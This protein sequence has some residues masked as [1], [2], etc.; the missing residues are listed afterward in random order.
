M[1]NREMVIDEDAYFEPTTEDHYLDAAIENR[2]G[3]LD[4]ENAA[5]QTYA[6]SLNVALQQAEAKKREAEKILAEGMNEYDSARAVEGTKALS[7][8]QR[9]FEALQQARANLEQG[10]NN[11]VNENALTREFDGYILKQPPR[12]QRYLKRRYHDIA[13]N[14]QNTLNKLLA[15]D[16]EARR[17]GIPVESLAYYRL[18]DQRAGLGDS[19]PRS[20]FV[21][22]I[23]DSA[24]IELSR[25]ARDFCR[26][27]GISE[28][29]YEREL[30]AL[31]GETAS[32]PTESSHHDINQTGYFTPQ[33]TR[34][35][36]QEA[37]FEAPPGYQRLDLRGDNTEPAPRQ[38]SNLPALTAAEIDIARSMGMSNEDYAKGKRAINNQDPG[39]P[40]WSALRHDAGTAKNWKTIQ[41]AER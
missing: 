40:Q 14:P 22:Q 28:E 5:M 38:Q 33:Q 21:R 18:L 8:A 3:R 13:E 36:P 35:V 2:A 26:D 9:E 12:V 23:Q 16:Q 30:R 34:D 1:A 41:Q 11:W 39:A 27:S 37:S 4:A 25:E 10:Y 6:G 24:P 20:E 29:R 31:K 7:E 17:E 15:A 32:R 19:S